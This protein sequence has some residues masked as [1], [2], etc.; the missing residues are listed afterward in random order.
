MSSVYYLARAGNAVSK[1][2][3]RAARYALGNMVGVVS[4]L[5]WRSKRRITQLNMA[6]VT[7]R[8]V[9]DPY[10]K[11]LAMASWRNY[12]RYAADFMHFPHTNMEAIERSGRDLTD[13][14]GGWPEYIKQALAT[15][16]G[17]IL[18]TAHFGSWDMAGAIFARRFALA[19]VAETFSDERLNSLLQNQRIQKGIGI[20][21]MEGSARRVL[22]VLQENKIV[23]IVGDRPVSKEE[24]VEVTFFGRKTY[25]PSG[26][27]A[28][29]IMSGAAI[30]PGFVW[31]GRNNSFYEIAFP[32]IFPRTGKGTDKAAEIARL[33]QYVY[34]ALEE[35]VRQWPTQWYMFRQFWPTE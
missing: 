31:Y 11:R 24:G 29:A 4:Y 27:A 3:P 10:V 14:A 20:I 16:H 7:G 21:P 34:D 17:A 26:P 15:G 28:L 2:T 18:A 33:T 35:M 23:A 32:P 30:L 8:P 12:G 22:R 25:V 1:W 9:D 13:C 6:Q 19:A 5:A